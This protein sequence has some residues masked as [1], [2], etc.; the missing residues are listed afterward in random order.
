M[1]GVTENGELT[2]FLIWKIVNRLRGI[3][4]GRYTDG[5][6]AV[7]RWLDAFGFLYP[8]AGADAGPQQ[9]I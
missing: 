1:L 7:R 3:N 2:K 8:A 4:R 5:L 6:Q 9:F